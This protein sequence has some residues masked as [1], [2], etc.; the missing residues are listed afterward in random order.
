MVEDQEGFLYPHIDESECI[1]CGLCERVCHELHPCDER[2][3]LGVYAAFNKNEEVRLRS[4][5]GGIFYLL[6]EQTIAEGG[7]VFGARFDKQWQAILDYAEEMSGVSAFMG[8]KYFQARTGR[9]FKDAEAFLKQGRKVL[10]SGSPC[11]IAGLHQ[12]L[13]KDYDNLTTVDFL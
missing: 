13:R 1:D 10:F 7:V 2:K 5:S 3:P 8:S 4:S 6:A 11:Q 12:F 9:A